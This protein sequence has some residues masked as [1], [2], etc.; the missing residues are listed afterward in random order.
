MFRYHLRRTKKSSVIPNLS[1]IYLGQRLQD[2]LS[3]LFH[4]SVTNQGAH[5]YTLKRSTEFPT[6]AV[7]MNIRRLVEIKDFLWVSIS[8][9][10]FTASI[11]ADPPAHVTPVGYINTVKYPEPPERV[12]RVVEDHKP[13]QF[14]TTKVK[15]VK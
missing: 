7:S 14:D 15:V 2:P 12:C 11:H 1:P 4:A 5:S 10:V 13:W 6:R 3:V 8:L 9:V